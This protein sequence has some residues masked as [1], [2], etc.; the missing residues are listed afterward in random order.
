M[1]KQAIAAANELLRVC[2]LDERHATDT[3][4]AAFGCNFLCKTCEEPIVLDASSVVS[5]HSAWW[6]SCPFVYQICLDW[7]QQTS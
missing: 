6:F 5:D 4:L 1:S 7:A 3:K 2:N